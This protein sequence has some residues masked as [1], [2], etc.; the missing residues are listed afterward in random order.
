MNW[1][2]VFSVSETATRR[3]RKQ[4]NIRWDAWESVSLPIGLASRPVINHQSGAALTTA[5]QCRLETISDRPLDLGN[6]PY[7]HC[8]RCERRKYLP[9]TRGCFPTFQNGIPNAPA[10]KSTEYFG[11][12]AKAFRATIVSRDLYAAINNAKLRGC[13]FT[14]VCQ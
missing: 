1:P 13:S 14:P 5:V 8:S 11:D 6:H 7:V 2:G 4:R 12:R 10:F 9:F 3:I